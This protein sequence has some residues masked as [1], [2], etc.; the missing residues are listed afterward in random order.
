MLLIPISIAKMLRTQLQCK[1]RNKM[2]ASSAVEKQMENATLGT[3]KN[4]G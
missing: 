1:L 4:K 2:L 3:S